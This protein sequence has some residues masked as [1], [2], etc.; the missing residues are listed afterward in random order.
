M[1]P[2]RPDGAWLP[3]LALL[4]LGG[5]L[6]W[7]L[8]VLLG[9]PAPGG[10]DPGLWLLAV[11]NLRAGSTPTTAPL[12][13]G[14]AAA[15]TLVGLD[16]HRAALLISGL[17]FAL[18]PPGSWLLARRLGAGSGGSIAAGLLGLALPSTLV[19]AVQI[20]ADALTALVLLATA[21][22]ATAWLRRAGWGTLAALA[23]CAAAL[24]LV[25]EHIVPMAGLM[26]VLALIPRGSVG[27]RL[28]RVA[29][30]LLAIAAAPLLLGQE[31]GFPWQ[32]VWFQ[33]RVGEA[34]RDATGVGIPRHVEQMGPRMR[35]RY[36]QAIRAGDQLAI[37]GLHLRRSLTLSWHAWS[38]VGLGLVGALLLPWR[39]R[40]A[41]GLVLLGAAPPLLAWSQPRHIAIFAP[42]AAAA[43]FAGLA[44]GGRRRAVVM[45]LV[46]LVV[47]GLAQ[48]EWREVAR[49][50]V[51]QARTRAELMDFGRAL[52]AVLEPGAVAIAGDSRKTAY[53]PLPR[54]QAAMGTPYDWKLV[55]LGE[56]PAR[57]P[58]WSSLE[59]AGWG[60]LVLERSLEPVYRLMPALQGEDRPCFESRPVGRASFSRFQPMQSLPLS[61]ACPVASPV[62]FGAGVP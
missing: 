21:L 11:E 15:L 50:Q 19:F 8:P 23:G 10:S 44:R 53:C 26:V 55:W 41:L 40:L 28:V 35:E 30:V 1:T 33:D 31:P 17:C 9:M 20:Q 42:V 29:A 57:H 54:V 7:L 37:T 39:R 49:K 22:T 32:Q 48:L 59:A 38:F 61:P 18:L 14:L 5:A 62:V 52:C 12:Y 46:A 60:P 4:A 3:P 43:W 56:M 2:S 58:A 16:A 13:P 27:V 24:S 47:V 36:E 6:P 45:G 34:A 25:R 51:A